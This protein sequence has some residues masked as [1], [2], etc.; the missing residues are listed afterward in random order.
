MV[1]LGLGPMRGVPFSPSVASRD[2]AQTNSIPANVKLMYLKGYSTEA[3]G[4]AHSVRRVDSEPS[5]GG[6][7][8]T[9]DRYLSD[10]TADQ[11][12]GGWWEIA[13]PAPTPEMFGAVGDGVADDTAAI[14][15]WLEFGGGRADDGS[16]VYSFDPIILTS[17]A[18]VVCARGTTFKLRSG[19]ADWTGED[20]HIEARADLSWSGGRFDGSR[21]DTDAMAGLLD[22]LGTS[23][24]DEVLNQY[25]AAI[26]I[27]VTSED[28]KVDLRDIDIVDQINLAVYCKGSTTAAVTGVIDDIRSERCGLGY[29]FDRCRDLYIGSIGAR[30]VDNRQAGDND[31]FFPA[32]F[33]VVHMLRSVNC[34]IRSIDIENVTGRAGRHGTSSAFMNGIT[35]VGNVRCPIHSAGIYGMGMAA[36]QPSDYGGQTVRETVSV[37]GVSW[38][39]NDSATRF[40]EFSFFGTATQGIEVI[41]DFDISFGRMLLWSDGGRQNVFS[42]SSA[43]NA[44]GDARPPENVGNGRHKRTSRISFTELVIRGQWHYGIWARKNVIEVGFC[45]IRECRADPILL[46]NDGKIE[47]ETSSEPQRPSVIVHDADIVFCGGQVRMV[48]GER[49]EIHAG[50]V[51]D[52][53]QRS[54]YDD[55]TLVGSAFT[56][57]HAVA[58]DGS[59]ANS[60]VVDRIYVSPDV[61]TEPL[62]KA[63]NS[64]TGISFM[65]GLPVRGSDATVPELDLYYGFIT[66]T[67][68]SQIHL[69]QRL[70]LKNLNGSSDVTVWPVHV[71]G[72][73]FLVE[74]AD[75]DK[76]IT[77]S[78]SGHLNTMQGTW[79]HSL[80]DNQVDGSGGDLSGDLDGP[81]FIKAP[82]GVLRFQNLRTENSFYIDQT[83][84]W[85][86][87][88]VYTVTQ[89]FSGATLRSIDTGYTYTV[90]QTSDYSVKDAN[91]LSPSA[92]IVNL[93]RYNISQLPA[94]GGHSGSVVY[95]ADE[96]GGAVLAFCDGSNWR[97]VTDRAVV[98]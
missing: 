44:H 35:W 73:V 17:P 51:S 33:H 97:R 57:T 63:V 24:A 49:L 70:V 16:K 9:A 77:W 8:R 19:W 40:D 41:T 42:G 81:A 58:Y 32:F 1:G 13:E 37:L 2:V 39:S 68:P 80:G 55:P 88:A 48:S 50:R 94:P 66:A 95:V 74:V 34:P 82:N 22:I 54:G 56:R 36:G 52:N 91:V 53:C 47:F 93:S 89:S 12:N 25:K 5:H 43:I 30:D 27:R 46:D 87:E 84:E 29:R 28:I 71:A 98:S 67:D 38:I 69:G 60:S 78:A 62:A 11:A 31:V 79:G 14:T 21:T 61:Q 72:D 86:T 23:A 6:K 85:G 10:G 64:A 45:S 90:S 76:A 20:G 96:T 3:D 83:T 15:D 59:D 65:P 18:S 92:G 26:Y 4:G 7:L 75:S